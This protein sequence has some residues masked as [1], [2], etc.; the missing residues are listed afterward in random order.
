MNIDGIVSNSDAVRNL[1]GFRIPGPGNFLLQNRFSGDDPTGF[2]DIGRF[3]QPV[4]RTQHA[5]GESDG[6]PLI[7]KPP[8]AAACELPGFGQ[9]RFH[10]RIINNIAEYIVI[11]GPVQKGDFRPRIRIVRRILDPAIAPQP[12]GNGTGNIICLSAKAKRL[13]PCAPHA[14][15]PSCGLPRTISRENLSY[16]AGFSIDSRSPVSSSAATQVIGCWSSGSP[17][18]DAFG[19]PVSCRDSVPTRY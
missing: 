14:S 16:P 7:P 17:S 10:C 12:E 4:F 19:S 9:V 5:S 3:G 15:H 6:V 13:N 2:P 18:S 11:L 1:P 8:D